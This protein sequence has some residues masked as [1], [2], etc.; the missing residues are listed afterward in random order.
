MER[1]KFIYATGC[2]VTVALGD[3]AAPDYGTRP[4]EVINRAIVDDCDLLVGVF[5]TRIGSSTGIADSGTLEE[6]ER[7]GKAGKPIMLYF[8]N[9]EIE[10]DKIDTT[11]YERLK[12][13]KLQT[14]PKGLVENY[15]KIIEFR[16][17]FARQLEIKIREIQKSDAPGIIPISLDIMSLDAEGK[18]VKELTHGFEHINVSNFDVAPKER[19]H[20][21]G[22]I[23]SSI[24]KDR[25]YFPVVLTLQNKGQLVYETFIF[26]WK[27]PQ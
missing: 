1:S 9:V 20:R 6:I 18:F 5:W 27:L 10:P 11:Q 14:Y 16:D 12:Q 23:A 3:H 19:Q 4:Q 22:E 7:V 2:P 17:K 25:S 21:L 13:F 26:S 24:I 15:K 8:S